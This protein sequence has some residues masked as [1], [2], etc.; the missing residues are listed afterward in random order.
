MTKT[1][2]KSQVIPFPDLK[3]SSA[4]APAP[5]SAQQEALHDAQLGALVSL[6]AAADSTADAEQPSFMGFQ[7]AILA[8]Q[9][10]E[11]AAVLV[12]LLGIEH[13]TALYVAEFF[14]NAY[15]KDK[16]V[17]AK[18]QSIRQDLLNQQ[19][20]DVLTKIYQCFGLQGLEALHLLQGLQKWL[21]R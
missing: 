16:S 6:R 9:T 3:P 12:A 13:S 2:P 5:T 18:A 8:G 21:N 4:P 15:Q 1:R 20:N 17:L 7:Q 11:A 14:G 19:I 10:A